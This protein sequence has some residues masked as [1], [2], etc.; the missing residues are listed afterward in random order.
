MSHP[1]AAFPFA[2]LLPTDPAR[3]VRDTGAALVTMGC[4]RRRL[5]ALISSG[6]AQAVE[7]DCVH[8]PNWESVDYT[9]D[10]TNCW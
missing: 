5:I 1:A 4:P 7:H 3:Q 9:S 2:Y 8:N 6:G 10:P